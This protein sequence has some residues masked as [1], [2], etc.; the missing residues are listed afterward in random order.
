MS[1]LYSANG[2]FKCSDAASSKT[3][4]HMAEV[5]FLPILY[6]IGRLLSTR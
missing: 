4:E 3:I 2:E 6:K 5:P 1:C